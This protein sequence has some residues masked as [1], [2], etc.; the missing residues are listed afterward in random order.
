M[1]GMGI[2]RFEAKLQG[3]GGNVILRLPKQA[4]AQ[5]PTRGMAVIEGTINDCRFKTVVE[6]DG[7]GG[8]LFRLE[9]NLLKT[10]NTFPGE[11]V[12]L[13]IEPTPEW[14]EPKMPADVDKILRAAKPEYALWT[15]ITPLARWDWLR[16]IGA[17]KNPE[18]RNRRIEKMVSMLR[19]GKRRP[20]CFDRTKCTIPEVSKNGLLLETEFEN[21]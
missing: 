8:H 3:W 10:L 12:K 21:N 19:L 16:F 4:S 7:R 5:L 2:Y 9:Q 11:A 13:E 1:A 6:P 20:C 15:K 18:T 14:P 17:T